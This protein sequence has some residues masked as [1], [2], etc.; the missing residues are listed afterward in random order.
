[1]AKSLLA[2]WKSMENVKD[3]ETSPEPNGLETKPKV[4]KSRAISKDRQGSP[5]ASTGSN[6]T[7][8]DCLPQ[9]GTAKSL[10]NKWQNIDSSS[11]NSRERKGPRPITPPPLEELQRSNRD[12]QDKLDSVGQ[13]KQSYHD[14]ELAMLRGNAKNTLAK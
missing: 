3:K 6:T 14:E 4:N 2:K 12:S 13:Q 1:M 8:D 7:S 11:S 5:T 10:L 9:S